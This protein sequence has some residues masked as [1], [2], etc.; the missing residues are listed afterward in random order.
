MKPNVKALLERHKKKFADNVIYCA[1][2]ESIIDEMVSELGVN[3][4]NIKRVVDAQFRILR[5]VMGNEGLITKN[6]DFKNYKSI[7]LIKLGSFRPSEKK[8][9]FIK[10]FLNKENNDKKD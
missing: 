9:K 3:K 1:E 8:F 6:S 5:E 4:M 7:R 2:I 10:E